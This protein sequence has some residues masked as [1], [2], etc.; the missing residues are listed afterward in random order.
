M[1]NWS[2]PVELD[3]NEL[4]V[5]WPLGSSLLVNLLLQNLHRGDRLP[6]NWRC[7]GLDDGSRPPVGQVEKNPGQVD[8]DSLPVPGLPRKEKRR[9]NRLLK[10]GIADS[11]SNF[12]ERQAVVPGPLPAD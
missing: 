11:V 6:E 4:P 8:V 5:S 7:G 1:K 9:W 2:R 3:G 12:G 10:P